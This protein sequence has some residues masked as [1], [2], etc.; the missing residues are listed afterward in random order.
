ML[1]ERIKNTRSDFSQAKVL[2]NFAYQKFEYLGTHDPRYLL[3]LV[4]P[5]YN[6]LPHT[7]QV[8]I[9]IEPNETDLISAVSS[10][11]KNNLTAFLLEE[12]NEPFF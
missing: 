1:K 11:S 8:S 12:D 10:L 2:K 9:K 4:T 5:E 3:F 6:N 7:V